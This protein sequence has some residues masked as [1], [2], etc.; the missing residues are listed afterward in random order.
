MGD[1]PMALLGLEGA[2]KHYYYYAEL[3][4][5]QCDMAQL[6]PEAPSNPSP[7]LSRNCVS[8]W[9][10]AD[11]LLVRIG[12]ILLTDSRAFSSSTDREKMCGSRQRV[13]SLPLRELGQQVCHA[14]MERLA[15]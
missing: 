11:T 9:M 7:T 8:G 6:A 15:S 10:K 5:C 3:S 1:D 4:L 2:L 13:A 14:V 12:T